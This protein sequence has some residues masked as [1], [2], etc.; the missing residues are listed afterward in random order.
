MPHYQLV[1]LTRPAGIFGL[2]ED[3]IVI[4]PAPAKDL[5]SPIIDLRTGNLVSHGTLSK[6]REIPINKEIT[7]DGITLEIRDNFIFLDIEAADE[8]EAIERGF[9][10]ASYYCVLLSLLT[11]R[12]CSFEIIQA[13]QE[14][15]GR[16]VRLPK[17]ICITSMTLYNL[18]ELAKRIDD[19]ATVY[20]VSDDNLGKATAYYYHALYMS[21]KWQRNE[22]PL[23]FHAKMIIA[24]VIL[25]FHKAIS[26]IIGDPSIDKDY[27]GSS[28][29]LHAF[30]FTDDE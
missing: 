11:N 21:E 28:F 10:I 18:E 1:L 15:E 25:T 5:P 24:E 16:K 19:I 4:H 22:N 26:T 17:S 9:R 29:Q 14:P 20:D 23:S 13:T 8:R 2:P 6:Y 27:C 3:G 7:L 12:Y 30:D